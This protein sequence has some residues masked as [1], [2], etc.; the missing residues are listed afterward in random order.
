VMGYRYTAHR[1]V[2]VNLRTGRAISGV[3]TKW[4]GPFYV[5]RDAT[6]YEPEGG[7]GVSAD[8]EV[9]VDK[10]NVDYIQAL[11]PRAAL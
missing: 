4:R 2:V 3:V 10:S 6:V 8:G 11:T 5:L 7:D 9:L 1:R